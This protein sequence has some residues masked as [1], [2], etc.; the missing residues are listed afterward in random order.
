MPEEMLDMD[1]VIQEESEQL[2]EDPVTEP[3]SGI[4]T[5]GNRPWW[6]DIKNKRTPQMQWPEGT[7]FNP[8][9][10]RRGECDNCGFPEARCKYNVEKGGN[11]DAKNRK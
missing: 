7:C 3:Q 9:A 2:F 6:W 1:G 8:I 10:K 4:G 11:K 5:K